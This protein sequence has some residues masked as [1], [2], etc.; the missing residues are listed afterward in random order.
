MKSQIKSLNQKIVGLIKAV[1]FLERENA[2][3]KSDIN[4][5]TT[6]VNRKG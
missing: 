3:R 5:I 1:S 2:R 6:A 4:Q